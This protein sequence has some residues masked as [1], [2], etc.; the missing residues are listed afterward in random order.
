MYTHIYKLY[1]YTYIYIVWYENIFG[2]RGDTLRGES[3]VQ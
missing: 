1:I 3:V 2:Q